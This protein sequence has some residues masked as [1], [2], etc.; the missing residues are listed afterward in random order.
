MGCEQLSQAL[1]TVVTSPPGWTPTWNCEPSKPFF[2]QVAFDRL[3]LPQQEEKVTAINDDTPPPRKSMEEKLGKGFPT[4]MS[5]QVS[6]QHWLLG[7]TTLQ[8]LKEHP[9]MLTL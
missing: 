2:P 8:V 4:W 3:F 6:H 7:C 9:R 5:G 1:A